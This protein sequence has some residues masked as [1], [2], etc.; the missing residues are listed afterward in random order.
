ML[1]A[2]A[3]LITQNMAVLEAFLA[4]PLAGDGARVAYTVPIAR[5]LSSRGFSGHEASRV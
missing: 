5:Q 2:R 1:S 4:G 3:D